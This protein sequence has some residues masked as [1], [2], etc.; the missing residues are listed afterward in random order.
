MLTDVHSVVILPTLRGRDGH[1]GCG[2]ATLDAPDLISS[3]KLSR[4]R[5]CLVLG[6]EDSHTASEWQ[7]WDSRL[8]PVTF[9][10]SC[11]CDPVLGDGRGQ[12]W[13]DTESNSS[14]GK[15]KE[16]GALFLL[17]GLK[18]AWRFSVFTV[19]RTAVLLCNSFFHD[20]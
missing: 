5:A 8:V 4:G 16:G 10:V 13:S 18:E 1:T 14:L 19:L 2:H 7:S 17:P 11:P 9:P 12:R 15:G 3:R 20:P 6:W